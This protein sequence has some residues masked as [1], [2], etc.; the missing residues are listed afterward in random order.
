MSRELVE[1]VQDLRMQLVHIAFT[2]YLDH[3][4]IFFPN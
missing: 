4:I 2:I 1:I 3:V